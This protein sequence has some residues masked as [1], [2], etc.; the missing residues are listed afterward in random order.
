MRMAEKTYESEYENPELYVT[1][2]CNKCGVE[3][4]FFPHRVMFLECECGNLDYG[5]CLKD[6]PQGKFGNFKFVSASIWHLP[7]AWEL[8]EQAI[9]KARSE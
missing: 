4:G 9:N 8:C 6:W 1:L 2:E 3:S 5:N 7:T